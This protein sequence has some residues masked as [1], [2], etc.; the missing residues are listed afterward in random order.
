MK[1]LL[2]TGGRRLTIGV[3]PCAGVPPKLKRPRANVTTEMI[4]VL[5]LLVIA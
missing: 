1:I 3:A 4:E 5:L 2:S